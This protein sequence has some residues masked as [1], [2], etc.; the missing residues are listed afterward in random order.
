MLKVIQWNASNVII[1]FLI[2]LITIF[3]SMNAVPSFQDKQ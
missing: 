2:I 1:S 3:L